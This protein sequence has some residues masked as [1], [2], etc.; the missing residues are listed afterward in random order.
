MTTIAGI[1]AFA[2]LAGAGATMRW[3]ASSR[4]NAGSPG[5]AMPW[6]TISANLVASFL[7]GVLHDIEGRWAWLIGVAFC[8]ALSTFSTFVMEIV[9]L[10]EGRQRRKALAYLGLSIGGGLL[11]AWLGVGFAN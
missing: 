7:L 9:L 1:I 3:W 5:T 2:S 11:A 4:W 6:G 10:D 8:G